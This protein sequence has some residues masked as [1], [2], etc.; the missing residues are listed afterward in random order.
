MKSWKVG[1]EEWP[2]INF[3]LIRRALAQ[4][5]CQIISI[6]FWYQPFPFFRIVFE[7]FAIEANSSSHFRAIFRFRFA[8]NSNLD[9]NSSHNSSSSSNS[10]KNS[11]SSYCYCWEVRT[12]GGASGSHRTGIFK[13]GS[14]FVEAVFGVLFFQKWCQTEPRNGFRNVTKS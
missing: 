2:D 5:A 13:W 14:L 11:S 10:N 12:R 3:P 4:L 8:I 1:D 9:T 7:T 6:E